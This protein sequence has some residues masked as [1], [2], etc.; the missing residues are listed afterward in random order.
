[1]S[2]RVRRSAT[3]SGSASQGRM[4]AAAL[5]EVSR[6][7]VGSRCQL[8]MSRLMS[9]Q[10]VFN[11]RLAGGVSRACHLPERYRVTS[12]RSASERTRRKTTTSRSSRPPLRSGKFLSPETLSAKLG[13]RISRQKTLTPSDGMISEWMHATSFVPSHAFAILDQSADAYAPPSPRWKLYSTPS[14]RTWQ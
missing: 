13:S 12:R 11:E 1:M 7:F 3:T 8:S 6:V 10:S 5:A 2:A 14:Q 9:R 4:Q